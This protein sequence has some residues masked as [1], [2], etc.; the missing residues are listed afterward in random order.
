LFSSAVYQ[1]L[2]SRIHPGAFVICAFLPHKRDTNLTLTQIL[3]H[4]TGQ[5]IAQIS[6]EVIHDKVVDFYHRFRTFATKPSST[7][8]FDL[9][10][11][12]RDSTSR[13]YLVLDAPDQSSELIASLLDVVSKAGNLCVMISS[14]NRVIEPQDDQI[15]IDIDALY[16]LDHRKR[17]FSRAM[18]SKIAEIQSRTADDDQ[19]QSPLIDEA[20]ERIMS[21]TIKSSTCEDLAMAAFDVVRHAF[22][23]LRGYQFKRAVRHILRQRRPHP[24]TYPTITD[25]IEATGG[26]LT[27]QDDSVITWFH[28]SLSGYFERTHARWFPSG[29]ASMAL[30]C[31]TVLMSQAIPTD[32][33]GTGNWAT[34]SLFGYAACL[35]GRHLRACS[36]N[37]VLE[38]MAMRYLEDDEKLKLGCLT[39][40][41]LQSEYMAYG[42]DVGDGLAVV[43]VCCIFGLTNLL[44]DLSVAELNRQVSSTGCAPLVYACRMGHIDTL[45]LLLRRGADP[46]LVSAGGYTALN[47]AVISKCI[48]AVEL[49]LR[50]PSLKLRPSLLLVSLLQLQSLEILRLALNRH[51][52]DINEKDHNGRTVIWWLLRA[53][54]D[55]Y[56]TE[57]QLDAMQLIVQHPDCDINAVDLG[58]RTYIMRLL[59]VRIQET[60]LLGLLL[61]NRADVNYMDEDGETAMF[62][63]VTTRYSLEITSL[64]IRHGADL[65]RKNRWGQGLSH[66][67]VADIEDLQ[68]LQYLD[69]L[70]KHMPALIDTQDDR[71][72]TSL[73]LALVF[74]KIEIAKEL[75]SRAANVRLLDNSGRAP[76]DV[77]CQYGRTTTLSRL[78]PVGIY[79]PKTNPKAEQS[80]I[81][82]QT[83][84]SVP[85]RSHPL[86][87]RDRYSGYP[88][89]LSRML[90]YERPEHRVE[91]LPDPPVYLHSQPT[92]LVPPV[93]S[94]READ[95]QWYAH[96]ASTAAAAHG[97][98]LLELHLDKLPGWSLGYLGKFVDYS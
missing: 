46:N 73:H 52:L 41:T 92:E 45:E 87:S 68:D 18:D 2:N 74:G 67:L 90:S 20:F 80:G 42:F 49:L 5:L 29:H 30:A 64:L 97:Q 79:K 72:R 78:V 48:P 86:P 9:I 96:T 4:L 57:F 59:D 82:S 43:H 37:P 81:A 51:D 21:H 40:Y 61:E 77:A 47:E 10:D 33:D 44:Q 91:W 76:F 94:G 63:A 54:H 13:V 27:I 15:T 38:A 14:S 19:R 17:S 89:P 34:G 75:L 93:T 1:D 36:P 26:L 31:L 24:I 62:H 7:V 35:W 32:A 16:S 8:L 11:S 50:S 84:R 56:D 98:V 53:T 69:L 23:P 58:G 22:S 6:L 85:L 65:A 70:L 95:I 71:G 88:E 60:K 3:T 39:A 55:E 28:P 12:L 83:P 66:R 25:V